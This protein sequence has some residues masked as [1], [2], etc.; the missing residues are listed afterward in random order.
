MTKRCTKMI[1]LYLQQLGSII[2]VLSSHD[3]EMLSDVS[4]L[5]PAASLR[6]ELN[7]LHA[8]SI[9]HL[10]QLHHKDSHSV[11]RELEKAMEHSRQQVP[12]RLLLP[13][14]FF[15]PVSQLASSDSPSAVDVHL[16]AGA[17]RSHLRPAR[18]A[19]FP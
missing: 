6:A 1:H 15:P 2:L 9:E 7:H 16:G 3:A 17:P 10:K 14:S 4:P 5:R 11:K 18:R 12:F 19:V 13:I 8:A